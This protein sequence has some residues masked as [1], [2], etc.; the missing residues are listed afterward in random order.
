MHTSS[1]KRKKVETETKQLVKATAVGKV[2]Q[3]TALVGHILSFLPWCAWFR[4]QRVCKTWQ[5]RSRHMLNQITHISIDKCYKLQAIP[6]IP[7]QDFTS[8]LK[9]I[10]L[11]TLKTM[12]WRWHESRSHIRRSLQTKMARR[13]IRAINRRTTPLEDVA[14]VG[15][16]D[17]MSDGIRTIQNNWNVR[18]MH[19]RGIPNYQWTGTA[20]AGFSLRNETGTCV[21][22]LKPVCDDRQ[23]TV[24]CPKHT[25][26]FPVCYDCVQK[27]IANFNSSHPGTQVSSQLHTCSDAACQYDRCPFCPPNICV[28]CKS[29]NCKGQ[30]LKCHAA[31]CKN[32]MCDTDTCVGT[33]RWKLMNCS[34]CSWGTDNHTFC[35]PCAKDQSEMENAAAAAEAAWD[36]RNPGFH[37][38]F[39][40]AHEAGMLDDSDD[41]LNWACVKED[42]GC[43]YDPT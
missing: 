2:V 39:E 20:G 25:L 8:I 14:L 13:L 15:W 16:T 11:P 34:V 9:V 5:A 23:K 3:H 42:E 32:W 6:T 35:K 1:S 12:E 38:D 41:I 4:D 22:C 37:E 29:T 43:Y 30:M 17:Y 10:A 28:T 33:K 7:R 27:D 21:T 36:A 18:L 19:Y 24:D 31:E 26:G 40:N